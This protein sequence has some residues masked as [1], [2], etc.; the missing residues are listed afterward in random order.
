MVFNELKI[1]EI[2]AKCDNLEPIRETLKNENSDFEGV[3]YQTDTYFKVKKGRLKLREGNIENNL[4]F[5]DR[6]N[7]CEPKRS[8]VILIPVEK[9]TGLKRILTTANGILTVVEKKREIYFIDNIKIHIDSVKQLGSFIEIE[10]IERAG[11]TGLGNLSKQ[12]ELYMKKS[13]INNSDL[14][15]CSY[16]DMIMFGSGKTFA[17]A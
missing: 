5:C 13:G 17:G 15:G 12:C 7:I 2:K 11:Y 14:V 16:S 3:D 1:I 8:E 4:I 6:E 9:G 10:A